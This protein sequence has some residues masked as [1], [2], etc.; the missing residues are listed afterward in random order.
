METVKIY[1]N[2]TQNQ[3]F[4]AVPFWAVLGV[5]LEIILLHHPPMNPTIQ[6]KF[7]ELSGAKNSSISMS[8]SSGRFL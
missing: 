8:A 5:F 7:P 6:K 1:G 3:P 4:W 2:T